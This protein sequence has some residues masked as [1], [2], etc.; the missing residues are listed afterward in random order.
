MS[1]YILRF[2]M[3]GYKFGDISNLLNS[4]STPET[5]SADLFSNNKAVPVEEVYVKPVPVSNK[6][7]KKTKSIEP[8]VETEQESKFKKLSP[9]QQLEINKRTLFVGNLPVGLKRKQLRKYIFSN[10]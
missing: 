8:E 10:Q 2:I 5:T 7:S 6:R 4:A 9:E 1:K 3:D